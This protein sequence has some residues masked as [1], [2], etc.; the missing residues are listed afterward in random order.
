[1]VMLHNHVSDVFPLG[2]GVSL[3]EASLE[4]TCTLVTIVSITH[5]MIF[6]A[7]AVPG[8]GSVGYS[9]PYLSREDFDFLKRETR[10]PKIFL[11]GF[12][13]VRELES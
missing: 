10:D 4:N 3:L 6:P 5:R 2:V 11:D 1:M 13:R 9:L 8:G 12:L 7:T